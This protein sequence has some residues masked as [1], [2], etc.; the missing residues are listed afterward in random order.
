MLND[1]IIADATAHGYNWTP[2]NFA[3]ELAGRMPTHRGV[4]TKS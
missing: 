4:F 2:G 3:V 1:M